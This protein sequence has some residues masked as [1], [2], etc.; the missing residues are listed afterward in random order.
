MRWRAALN[1][2]SLTTCLCD[3]SIDLLISFCLDICWTHTSPFSTRLLNGQHLFLRP[4]PYVVRRDVVPNLWS[5]WMLWFVVL[6][7]C[8]TLY[9]EVFLVFS[10]FAYSHWYTVNGSNNIIGLVL[11]RWTKLEC[12]CDKPASSDISAWLMYL[13]RIGLG[14]FTVLSF[15]SDVRA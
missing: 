7:N 12:T 14:R 8:I 10:Y 2:Y 4:R 13:Y 1:S 9:R 11:A 3:L 5:F 15:R 6:F